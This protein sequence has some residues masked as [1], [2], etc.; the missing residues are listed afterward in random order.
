MDMPF[1]IAP[2]LIDQAAN[3]TPNGAA[4]AGIGMI[5]STTAR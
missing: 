2:D 4:G 3:C 1:A 5:A